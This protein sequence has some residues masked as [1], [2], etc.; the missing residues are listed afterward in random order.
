RG[1][2]FFVGCAPPVK[3][4]TAT[5]YS[6]AYKEAMGALLDGS[7]TYR[8]CIPPEVP[9]RQFWSITV[10]DSGTQALIRESPRKSIDSYD[11]KVQKNPDGS[12]EVYFGPT[13]P[14]GKEANWLYTAPGKLWWTYFRFYGPEKAVFDK[15]WQLP[16]IERVG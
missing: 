1:T 7:R 2:N 14:D 13:A 16:D 6:G 3:F 15:T 9:A 5:F 8:L 10:Y 12:L 11:S 4:G